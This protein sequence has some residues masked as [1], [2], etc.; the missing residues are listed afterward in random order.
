M[1]VNKLDEVTSKVKEAYKTKKM[2]ITTA[3]LFI[4]DTLSKNYYQNVFNYEYL[5]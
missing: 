1:N 4:P 2:Q 3:T 5:G